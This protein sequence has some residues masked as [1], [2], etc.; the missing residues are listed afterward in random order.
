MSATASSQ[1]GL[2]QNGYGDNKNMMDLNQKFYFNFLAIQVTKEL[3]NV[4][5]SI[6]F[7]TL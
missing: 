6:I 4:I 2:S 7:I 5:L 1:N 3:H